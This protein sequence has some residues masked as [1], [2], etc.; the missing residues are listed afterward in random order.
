MNIIQWL[1]GPTASRKL[2][3]SQN[4]KDEFEDLRKVKLRQGV[5]IQ[6]EQLESSGGASINVSIFHKA[7]TTNHKRVIVIAVGNGHGYEPKHS[8]L[9]K[10]AKKYPDA[11][12]AAFNFRNVHAST[13]IVYGEQDWI[14]DAKAVALYFRQQGFKNQDILFNGFSLGGA[15]CTMMVNQLYQEDKKKAAPED[16]DKVKAIRLVNQRSLSNISAELIGVM[17]Q[18]ISALINTAIYAIT[19]GL[20]ALGVSTL[21]GLGA[22]LGAVSAIGLGIGAGVGI[23]SAVVPT[24][25][26]SMLMPWMRLFCH[27]TFG[28]MDALTAYHQIPE[29][30]KDYIVARHDSR[31]TEPASLHLGLRS[32]TNKKKKN[33]WR[34]IKSLSMQ[35]DDLKSGT[36]KNTL[37]ARVMTLKNDLRNIH[38]CEVTH[39][40][41]PHMGHYVHNDPLIFFRTHNPLR[42]PNHEN[43]PQLSGQEVLESKIDRLFQIKR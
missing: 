22:T 9:L 36:Q 31:I 1:F 7:K 25:C 27:V 3:V 5:R 13:G 34:E 4:R 19:P 32:A 15:I 28:Q 17:G 41:V 10:L 24:F 20:L 2:M 12:I 35:A 23:L 14:D 37:L 42:G 11:L 38:D 6:Q 43:Y 16:K 33:L 39:D 18:P 40:V 26:A 8:Q 30:A 29:D 21:F